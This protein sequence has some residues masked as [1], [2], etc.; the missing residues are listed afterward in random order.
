MTAGPGR[1][2]LRVAAQM[3][4][5]ALAASAGGWQF[6]R[7]FHDAS[8]SVGSLWAVIAGL[9]VLQATRRGTWSAAGR[10]LVSSVV[11]VIVSTVGL[12]VL[13]FG[14]PSLAAAVLAAVLLCHATGF[15]DQ[16]KVAAITVVVMM[17]LASLHSTLSPA[18]SALLRFC[19]SCIG[20][21]TALLVAL[22]GPERASGPGPTTTG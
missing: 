7:L 16:A 17:V 18:L 20:A 19:E 15:A 12:A 13:P 22:A 11:G 8:A 21:A 5:V 14:A 6:T 4:L 1:E 2:G 10:H 9:L 3:G